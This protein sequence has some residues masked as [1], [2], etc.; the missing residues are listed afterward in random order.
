MV[1][2]SSLK[3]DRHCFRRLDMLGAD[4]I[5]LREWSRMAEELKDERT[6]L[7][8]R[9]RQ[10]LWR[11]FPQALEL[12]D[13]V[14]VDWFLDLF[15]LAPTPQATARLTEMKIARVL[16]AHRI[17]RITAG[18]ALDILRRPA[19]TVAAGTAEAASAHI[20]AAAE[21][22]RLVNRQLKDVT[23]RIDVLVSALS[24]ADAAESD[25]S[26]QKVEQHDAT[27][28]RSLPG[29]GRPIS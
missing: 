17:R 5:A 14:G 3:T 15:A 19:L 6:R 21:G 1:L 2:A 26:G 23:R 16:R 10:Q 28:L 11:Y 24:G 25:Q 20:A 8:N 27:I 9:I 22:V 13:D 7:S 29:V 4:I 12:N 18:E